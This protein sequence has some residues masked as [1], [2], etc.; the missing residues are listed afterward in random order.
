MRIYDLLLFFSLGNGCMNA[1][2][3]AWHETV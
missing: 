2:M 3:N 1:F